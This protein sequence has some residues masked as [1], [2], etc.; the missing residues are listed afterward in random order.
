M[1]VITLDCLKLCEGCVIIE[2]GVLQKEINL[3]SSLF[4]S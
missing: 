1:P 2:I 4:V 3:I